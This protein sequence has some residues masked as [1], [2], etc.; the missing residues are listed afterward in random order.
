MVKLVSLYIIS[1]K[2]VAPTDDLNW[3]F[4]VPLEEKLKSEEKLG[5]EGGAN[6]N[7]SNIK[8]ENNPP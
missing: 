3:G 8:T 5:A 6:R 4:T 7:M 1:F 2:V